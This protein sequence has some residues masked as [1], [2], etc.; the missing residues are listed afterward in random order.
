MDLFKTFI[1]EDDWLIMM[2]AAYHSQ[3]V[4]QKI[5]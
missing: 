4:T 3:I 2:N 1:I 5:K